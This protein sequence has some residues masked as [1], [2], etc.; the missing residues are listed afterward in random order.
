MGN[1]NHFS[2][3]LLWNIFKKIAPF[4]F[5]LVNLFLICVYP[6]I[7]R[8]TIYPDKDKTSSIA[9][10]VSSC[11][12]LFFLNQCLLSG[13]GMEG[14]K[15]FRDK[16]LKYYATIQFCIFVY[17]VGPSLGIY[18]IP[19]VLNTTNYIG[20]FWLL[21]A[22][23]P[24]MMI[25]LIIKIRIYNKY[26]IWQ[27]K[28]MW[29]KRC[30]I[31]DNTIYWVTYIFLSGLLI[32]YA[33]ILEFNLTEVLVHVACVIG[34]TWLIY[35][36]IHYSNYL[37]M[38]LKTTRLIAMGTIDSNV[39]ARKRRYSFDNF[40]KKYA[41]WKYQYQVMSIICLTLTVVN[42]IY[43]NVDY[44]PVKTYNV[45]MSS[46]LCIE[47]VYLLMKDI[48]TCCVSYCTICCHCCDDPVEYIEENDLEQG[49]SKKCDNK[50]LD[51]TREILPKAM[52][53]KSMINE[54]DEFKEL[55]VSIEITD[56]DLE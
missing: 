5:T 50:K 20:I 48:F 45:L 38:S 56:D 21:L 22:I 28:T 51:N 47:F 43:E 27:K 11:V 17:L 25:P 53:K 9:Y 2:Q 40:H 24:F 33:S 10:T 7:L 54:L 39:E 18:W 16:Y 34:Y 46:M 12:F 14:E 29:S 8:I 19:G 13:P 26:V 42:E 41:K 37:D 36:F 52:I 23:Q 32:V 1:N 44:V 30:R 15:S 31:Y 6:T 4:F 3:C 55:E 35:G 49:I